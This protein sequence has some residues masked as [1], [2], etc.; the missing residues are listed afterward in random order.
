[1]EMVKVLWWPLFLSFHSHDM[2]IRFSIFGK[3]KSSLLYMSA[4]III[5]IDLIA[6]AGVQS[7][8]QGGRERRSWWGTGTRFSRNNSIKK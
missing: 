5:P 4:E 8:S 6:E 2:T 7:Q 1:M 3:P